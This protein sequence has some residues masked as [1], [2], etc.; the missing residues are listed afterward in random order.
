VAP[1]HG[2]RGVA[3]RQRGVGCSRGGNRA[4]EGRG[5]PITPD[6]AIQDLSSRPWRPCCTG[7]R[8]R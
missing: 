1:G 2:S 3:S 7:G 8:P 5:D 4:L 6:T